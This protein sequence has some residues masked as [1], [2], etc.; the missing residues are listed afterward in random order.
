VK[1]TAKGIGDTVSDSATKVGER[2]KQAEPDAKAVGSELH[3]RA[4]GFG[5]AILD[6]FKFVGRTVANF[7]TGEK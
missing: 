7:F 5:E 6:G 2:A 3:D 1:D 4:K